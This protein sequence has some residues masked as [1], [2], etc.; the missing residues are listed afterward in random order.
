MQGEI[1]LFGEYENIDNIPFSLTILQNGRSY[2]EYDS[3]DMGSGY[4]DGSDDDNVT[5]IDIECDPV[6]DDNIYICVNRSIVNNVKDLSSDA[7]R[8]KLVI[9][10]NILIRQNKIRWPRK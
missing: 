3:S 7:M 1:R 8:G 10:F 9:I 6:W 4:N 5:I 2:R